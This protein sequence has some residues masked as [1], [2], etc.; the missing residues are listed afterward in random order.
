ML[1]T[2]HAVRREPVLEEIHS[3]ATVTSSATSLMTVAMTLQTS[4]LQVCTRKI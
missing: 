1:A 4:V 3:T 2:L